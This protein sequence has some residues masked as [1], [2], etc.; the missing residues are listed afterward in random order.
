MTEEDRQLSS[1]D[2][3]FLTGMDGVGE[4]LLVRHAQQEFET[5]T[6]S[7]DPPSMKNFIDPPLSER[8]R[9]QAKLVG[10]SLADV[11]LDAVYSSPLSRAADTAR[12]I[13]GHHG[14]ELRII[15][16]LREVEIFRDIPEDESPLS[17]LSKEVLEAARQRMVD[18]RSWDVYPLSE[19]SHEFRRR[20]ISA[21][22]S[23]IVGHPEQRIAIVC[24]G[25]VINAYLGHL[26][27]TKF[28]MFFRPAHT[29]VNAVITR[30]RRR[31][32]RSLNEIQHLR[33]S[34]GDF[35]TY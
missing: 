23:A 7:G 5:A 12:E 31:A 16:D 29:A 33:T 18:E 8:G 25:G 26:I 34:E 3:A 21:V 14:L 2:Q 24:H 11:P 1:F 30:R 19:S 4:V 32:L 27:A 35:T 22:E 6:K 13:A 15:D 17:V 28:D 10:A 20:V 9:Q